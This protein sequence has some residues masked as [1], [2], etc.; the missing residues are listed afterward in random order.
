VRNHLEWLFGKGT[1]MEILECAGEGEK[2]R[3]AAATRDDCLGVIPGLEEWPYDL[4]VKVS[5]NKIQ[6]MLFATRSLSTPQGQVEAVVVNEEGQKLAQWVQANRP[7]DMDKVM[8]KDYSRAVGELT[9][10]VCKAYIA[11]RQ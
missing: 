7:G 9:S 10:Q 3:C 11:A 2:W 1:T 4:T 5:D 6:V 8:S